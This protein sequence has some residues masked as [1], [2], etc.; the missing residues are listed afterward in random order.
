MYFIQ[1]VL[2]LI[3]LSFQLRTGAMIVQSYRWW[4][5]EITLVYLYSEV[6]SLLTFRVLVTLGL[7]DHLPGKPQ[8][9]RKY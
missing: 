6:T 1:L 7:S 3:F 8:R 4:Q 2:Q 9:I 5:P